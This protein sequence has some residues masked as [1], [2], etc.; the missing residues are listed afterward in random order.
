VIVED[1]QTRFLGHIVDEF[2]D[3]VKRIH[4]AASVRGHAKRSFSPRM[5]RLRAVSR[6]AIS[7]PRAPRR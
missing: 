2:V 6:R 4:R 1:G 7:T 5:M 3:A